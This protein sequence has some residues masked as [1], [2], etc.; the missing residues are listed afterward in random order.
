MV[1]QFTVCWLPG[2]LIE[3]AV[4]LWYTAVLLSLGRKEGG[5][6]HMALPPQY[7]RSVAVTPFDF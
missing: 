4:R 1:L 6:V 2:V 3:E 5:K 7:V